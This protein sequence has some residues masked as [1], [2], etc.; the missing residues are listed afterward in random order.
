MELFSS[1]EIYYS[2]YQE[3]IIMS[4]VPMQS[5]S[6]P[7]KPLVSST[8]V[9]N[10]IKFQKKDIDLVVNEATKTVANK[11][12]IPTA[13]LSKEIQDAITIAAENAMSVRAKTL[14]QRDV[15][16]AVKGV[17]LQG[18]KPLDLL[19][20]RVGAAKAGMDHIIQ[21]KNVSDVLSQTASLLWQK[22]N[23]FTKVGFSTDQA[24][25]LL[26]AEVKGRASRER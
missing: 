21:N 20:A 25:A 2:F 9:N 17:V 22:Y 15:D 24:F 8:V 12:G 6:L 23:A 7:S 26:I 4:K 13:N 10:E 19:D 11:M 5:T 16:T 3:E 14:I 1:D 18:V